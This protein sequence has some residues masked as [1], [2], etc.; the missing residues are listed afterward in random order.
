MTRYSSLPVAHFR[1]IQIN[2]S[3]RLFNLFGGRIV[4]KQ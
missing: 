3:D 4:G 2:G 1:L